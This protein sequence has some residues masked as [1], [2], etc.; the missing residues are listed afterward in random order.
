MKIGSS[1]EKEILIDEII[2]HRVLEGSTHQQCSI[3]GYQ[4]N[5]K[6]D[7]LFYE[8]I[9]SEIKTKQK[10][11]INSFFPLRCFLCKRK[12]FAFVV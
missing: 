10:R 9:L 2:F 6:S 7:Y 4:D 1:K 3:W 11:K 8:K 12:V 5:F